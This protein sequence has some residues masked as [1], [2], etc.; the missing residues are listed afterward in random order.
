MDSFGLADD[1]GPAKVVHV[2]EPAMGLRAVLVVDNVACG[3]SIGGL[4]IAPDM[5]TEE[6]ARLAR[7]MTL[8]NAAAGLP[9]GGGKSVL[10]GDPRTPSDRKERLIRAFAHALRN[11]ED[12][13][14]GPDMGTDEHCMAWVKDE[15]GRAVGL[16]AALGGIPLDEIGATG[17]GILHAAEV[18]APYC[19]FGLSGA[20]VVVQGFGAVGKHSA[21]FLTERGAVLVAASD[22]QGAIHDPGGLAVA[23]LIALKDAGKSVSDYAGGRKLDRDAALDVDCEIWIPAARPDVVR[24]DNV[25][26]LKAKLV[27]SGA[28]IPVTPAAETA[29]HD[30]GVI[31]VPDFIANAG[32]VICAAMEYRGA[33]RAVAFATI[34]EKIR[35]NTRAVLETARTAGI[36]P[37]RAA[38]DLASERVRAAMSSRRFSIF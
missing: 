26:R 6:C 29:L 25:H 10:Y 21:R 24:D 9:H 32:G 16:P 2:Y 19:G 4:R 36:T 33:T 35:D 14:F 23:E 12:Y 8:K 5:S 3:P 15:I 11:E 1:L 7:A 22:S 31:V 27:L 18:A 37:R 30:R 17:W 20:R 13:I 38:V 34:E 28:N